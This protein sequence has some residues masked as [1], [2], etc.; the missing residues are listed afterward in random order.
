MVVAVQVRD[1]HRERRDRERDLDFLLK[2]SVAIS[3]QHSD[4][5]AIS[6]LRLPSQVF[7]RHLNLPPPTPTGDLSVKLDR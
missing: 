5:L 1:S 6:I 2:R 3:E 4:G 7:R